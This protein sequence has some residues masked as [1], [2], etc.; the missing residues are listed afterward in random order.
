MPAKSHP[1]TRLARGLAA[2]LALA[3][4]PPAAAQATDWAT[5]SFRP[6]NLVQFDNVIAAGRD[7]SGNVATLS[8]CV[9]EGRSGACIARVDTATGSVLWSRFQQWGT[10]DGQADIAVAPGGDVHVIQRCSSAGYYGY[11]VAKLQAADGAPAW[12]AT[13]DLADPHFGDARIAL[14]GSGNAIVAG[15]C[16]SNG[17]LDVAPCVRKLNAANGTQAWASQL[18]WGNLHFLDDIAGLAVDGSGNVFLA[19]TCRVGEGSSAFYA[20]ICVEKLS[21]ATGATAWQASINGT[22]STSDDKGRHLAILP[23]G[24]VIAGGSCN[25][26]S[27]VARLDN[28]T[29]AA[30][31]FRAL[32]AAMSGVVRVGHDGVAHVLALSSCTNGGTGAD[33]CVDRLDVAN[34]NTL[35]S[36]SHSGPGSFTD[37]PAGLVAD[38]AGFAYVAGTCGASGPPSSHF[39]TFKLDVATGS[40]PWIAYHA[41]PS[42]SA[43]A[44]RAVQLDAAGNPVTAGTCTVDSVPYACFVA[45]AAANAA[46]AWSFENYSFLPTDTR[47]R[48]DAE[49][50]SV[51]IARNGG[52]VYS[53]ASCGD[54]GY[55]LCLTKSAETT[56]AMAWTVTYRGLGSVPAALP[57]GIAFAPNGDPVVAATC[58]AGDG[59]VKLCAI[60][61]AAA[62]GAVAWT[63]R[64]SPPGG[65]DSIAR[66]I[67]VSPTGATFVTGKCLAAS[68]NHDMCTAAFS[69][70]DGA[71]LWSQLRNGSQ[72]AGD[73]GVA[74]LYLPNGVVAATGRCTNAGTNSDICTSLFNAA[75]GTPLWDATYARPG[76]GRDEPRAMA[77]DNFHLYVAGKCDAG[78]QDD[79]C[80]L[81]ISVTDGTLA[82]ASTFASTGSMDDEPAA[83]AVGPDGHPVVFGTCYPLADSREFGDLCTVKLNAATGAQ[84]WM[85]RYL[86]GRTNVASAGTIDPEGNP[87]IAGECAPNLTGRIDLCAIKYGGTNGAQ[88]WMYSANAS[89]LGYAAARGVLAAPGFLLLAGEHQFRWEPAGVRLFR[90]ANA[91]SAPTVASVTRVSPNP[92]SVTPLV[93]E[94]VFSEAVTGVSSADFSVTVTGSVTGAAATVLSGSGT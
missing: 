2:L 55:D 13:I 60:R 92:S 43:N 21:G 83:I 93:Y 33:I 3:V 18:S 5:A 46:A 49:V 42:S 12:Y 30:Q 65:S 19:G 91:A 81:K 34:G 20:N 28:A 11:C 68:G 47:Y 80:T 31:W 15:L 26:G 23:T 54:S 51:P 8:S 4:V 37:T 58:T 38:G 62:N 76:A 1:A 41:A 89:A 73:E 48:L 24:A 70:A 59:A 6:T 87:V 94:V 39:C 32:P 90:V 72:D 77:T 50:P 25:G 35:W 78:G 63:G 82:W 79:F 56:G 10:E 16:P 71:V 9:V 29:G 84:L 69:A 61:F 86:T 36:A 44:A 67:A 88:R 40:K 52:F 85:S 17:G 7:A 57:A 14:D 27:C 75:S 22:S 66:A 64:Y 53:A 45:N 74:V